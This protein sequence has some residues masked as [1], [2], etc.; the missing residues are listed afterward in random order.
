MLLSS[1]GVISCKPSTRSV[2]FDLPSKIDFSDGFQ[3]SDAD[4]IL[5]VCK[6]KDIKLAVKPD[7]NVSFEPDLSA[8][9]D[10]SA[11]VLKYLKKS[12]IAIGFVGNDKYRAPQEGQ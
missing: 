4:A 3:Q 1:L 7:G 8:D 12:G 5:Q 2:E 10:A 6:A 9:Y 11:C